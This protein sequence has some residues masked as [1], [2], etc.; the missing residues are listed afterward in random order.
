MIFRSRFSARSRGESA[1]NNKLNYHDIVFFDIASTTL[2]FD[3]EIVQIG[4]IDSVTGDEFEV[5]VD[6]D[7]DNA[8]AKALADCGYDE[9]RW[10]SEGCD[11]DGALDGFG[12]FLKRHAN[13]ERMSK[14]GKPY[15][16]AALGGFNV[17]G[18]DKILIERAFRKC[19]T[20]MPGDYR[21]FDVY[22]LALW[23]FPNLSSYT[24][25]AI[26]SHIGID[27]VGIGT[28][29]KAKACFEIA[30]FITSKAF[31]FQGVNWIQ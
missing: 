10:E 28:L 18:F 3:G 4:A 30:R 1:M 27:S 26:C 21:M 13:L 31:K 11:L 25:E 7:S 17:Y 24:L 29:A 5:C 2:G 12:Q 19:G 20:F 6:F 16:I 9:E 22:S 14:N 23:R 8:D 15:R